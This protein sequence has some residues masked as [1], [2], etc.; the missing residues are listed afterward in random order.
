MVKRIE[1]VIQALPG[2]RVR[3]AQALREAIAEGYTSRHLRTDLLSGIV[4]GVVALP[5]SMALAIACGVPP[6]HG[7]YTAIIAGFVIALL[8]GSR[9]Q[10]SG[11]TAAFVVI[12]APITERYGLGGLA[13][14]S[15]MAGVLLMLMGL[16]R[17]GTLIQFIPYPVTTG[18]TAGIAVVIATLQV[19]DFLGL[20][21]AKMPEHYVQ[22]VQALV[23]A[24]PT[25]NWPDVGI[26]VGTLVMLLAWPRLI[27][28]IPAPLV[29]LPL[30]AVAGIVLTSAN[31]DWHVATINTRFSYID[32]DGAMQQGIPRTP[33]LTVLPW[34]EA[35]PDG[36]PMH[37][38]FNMFRALLIASF[39]I[40]MLGA[41]ESLLSAVVSDGMINKT[42]D[43]N[44]ELLAQGAGN[45]VA[46]FFGGFAATGAIARTATNVRSGGRSPIA[47]MTHA[48]FVLAAMVSLAPLL[49]YLPMAS[50]AALLLV[51]AKNMSEVKHFV[52]VLRVG[53]R[54]DVAVLLTCFLLT[55]TFDMTIAV[56]A[57]IVLAAVLFMRRMAEVSDVQL[58]GST[59]PD[60]KEPL[61]AGI[62]L[63]EINGPLFFGAAQK[64]MSSLHAIGAEGGRTNGVK[65]VILDVESVPVLDA[66]GLVNLQST[67]LRLHRDHVFCVLAGVQPQPMEVL[68]KA[69]LEEIDS[70]I[71]ICTTLDEAVTMAKFQL[72]MWEDLKH[73]HAHG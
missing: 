14:A 28:R 27:R 68:A 67:I 42:H 59:H 32:A 48:A 55:V 36:Q 50:L 22:K 53:P 63:Y 7:L 40:A 18:F 54:S 61:P 12:L 10:V 5:L 19:K 72:A 65:V 52:Y 29:A 23:N 71:G 62:M 60:L 31:P 35:G 6:Q 49:G 73:S 11:P 26:G 1:T 4:V 66:T 58:I 64:A 43:P 2:L 38:D 70:R 34:H 46:P 37:V 24:L 69:R 51:V 56:S 3:P 33:P 39:A 20:S 9:V 45:I 44:A 25:I 41:I 21:I 16:L 8:G 57:G 17:F 30:A 15:V 13:C 47:S